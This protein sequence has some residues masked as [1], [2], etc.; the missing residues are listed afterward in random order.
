MVLPG[1]RAEIGLRD[2]A[3][4]AGVVRSIT[5]RIITPDER[6]AVTTATLTGDEWLMLIYPDD[7]AGGQT[8]ERGAYT[9][10]WETEGSFV[11]CDGFVVGGGAGR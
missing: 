9:I 6:E 7:L 11:A 4:Q 10:L 1:D 2:K 5:V 8:A 3:G